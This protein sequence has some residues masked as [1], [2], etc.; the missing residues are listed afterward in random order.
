MTELGETYDENSLKLHE[1]DVLRGLAQAEET[2]GNVSK[3]A[4][5]HEE[6]LGLQREFGDRYREAGSLTNLGNLAVRNG[7]YTEAQELMESA[8]EIM[9]DV[10]AQE[11]IAGILMNLGNIARNKSDF[12][13]AE[14]Y[15]RRARRAGRG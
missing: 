11:K 15:Y 6:S 12:D 13:N 2:Y 4:S 1:S 7:R 5:L 3:A 8:L 14:S 9:E 10:G